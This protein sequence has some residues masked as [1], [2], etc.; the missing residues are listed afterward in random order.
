MRHPNKPHKMT[1][2]QFL[3]KMLL[4]GYPPKPTYGRFG[5]LYFSES[6]PKHSAYRLSNNILYWF[7]PSVNTY[8]V[9][10]QLYAYTTYKCPTYESLLEKIKQ[11]SKELDNASN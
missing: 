4:L 3:T 10:D 6:D 11:L 7:D 8:I 5:N 9:A 2:A 1:E